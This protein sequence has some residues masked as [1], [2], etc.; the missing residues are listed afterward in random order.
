MSAI[1]LGAY[2]LRVREKNHNQYLPLNKFNG[3]NNIFAYL[4]KFFDGF[5]KIFSTDRSNQKVSSLLKINYEGKLISGIIE[6]GEYGYSSKLYDIDQGSQTYNRKP[7]EAELFPLYFLFDVNTDSTKGILIL[8]K[9]GNN[10]LFTLLKNMLTTNF[11]K[12]FPEYKIDINPLIP[13]G[14]FEYYLGKGNLRKLTFTT[15]KI[16]TDVNK[17]YQIKGYEDKI[18]EVSISV[19]AKKNTFL[20]TPKWI[21]D[22]LNGKRTIA[23]LIELHSQFNDV[24]IDVEIKGVKRTLS[25]NHTERLNPYFDMTDKIRTENGHPVFESINTEA[26]QLL[27]EIE[28]EILLV[29]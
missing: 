13:K 21:R 5:T 20:P 17:V 6:S 28:K 14:L 2:T 3:S 24:K 29:N 18:K 22:I 10:G 27:E 26:K 12:A 19:I 23:G 16:P 1:L 8:E 15:Y 11:T 25:I 7:K 9:F 4:K